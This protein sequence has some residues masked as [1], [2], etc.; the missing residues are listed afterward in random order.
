MQKN[1]SKKCK[2][3]LIIIFFLC[4]ELSAHSG[5][6]SGEKNLRVAKTKWFDIIYP[7]RC[8]ESAS[9]LFEKADTVYDEVT[10]QYG[11]TPSFRIPV[12]ITPAVEQFN[13]FW[14]GVP[15]NHIAIYDT[16]ASGD[17]DLS[18]FSETLLSTFRHELTHAVTYN[19]KNAFWRGMGKV[20]GDCVAPGMFSV[21]TGM[22][23][24]ATVA[25]ESSAGQGRL[26]DEFAKHY[27]KQ[28][29][30]EDKFPSYHDVSGASDV[31]PTSA[32]YYFNG[33]FHGWLQEKYGLPAYADFWWRVV[34]G[35]NFTIS[36]SFKKAFGIKLKKA[37]ALFE[38][39]YEVPEDAAA[40]AN[41]V[42]TGLVQDFF[43][44]DE[45]DY[46]IM[47]SAGFLYD[48]LSV[49]EKRL[50]WYD[51]ISSRVYT[52]S[53]ENPDSYDYVFTLRGISNISLS[54]D[55]RFLAVSYN[56]E[57]G[58]GVRARVRIYDFDHKTFYSVNDTGLRDAAVI[59]KNGDCYLVAQKYFAQHYSIVI[60]KLM[61]SDDGQQIN[62]TEP[63]AEVKLEAETNPYGFIPL[64]DGTFAYLKKEHLN[65]SIC[66]SDVDDSV[67]VLKE[68]A[69]PAGTVVRTFSYSSDEG[70]SD[71]AFYFSYAQKETMPRL[72]RLNLAANQFEFSEKDISGGVFNPVFWN[73][74]IVYIGEF[75]RQNR[76]LIM[77]E[78]EW[79]T[80]PAIAANNKNPAAAFPTSQL[81]SSIPSKTF[82]PFPYLL[83]GIIIPLSFYESNYFGSN[84]GYSSEYNRAYIG[85]TYLTATPWSSGTSELIM[86][87]GGWNTL[88]NSA[89]LS[90][91]VNS[92]TATSLFRSTTEVK[93]EFDSKG[94]KQ[95][96]GILTISTGFRTGNISRVSI[97]NTSYALFGRQDERLYIT[98]ENKNTFY[99]TYNFWDK[100]NIGILAPQID[101]IYMG[102]SDVISFSFSTIR[103]AGPGRFETQGIS[104]SVSYGVWYDKDFSN[105]EIEDELNNSI[106]AGIKVCIPRLL[107]FESKTGFTYNFPVTCNFKVLPS[108]KNLEK[109]AGRAVFAANVET[110]MFSIDIQKAI[111]FATAVFLNDF[112]I[113]GG[114]SGTGTAGSASKAG[115]Q[116]S[117][118]DD[119]FSAVSDG[120]GYYFDSIYLKTALEFIPNVGVLADSSYKMGLSVTYS[121]TL[122]S[123]KKLR[124]QE[125]T[126]ISL[127]LDM[128]F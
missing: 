2:N 56:S 93:S 103:K 60:F 94:W 116:T 125:R 40:A 96:G 72:G 76:L 67:S 37:W 39:E 3:F 8:E 49:S 36:G 82:S 46:S 34:N 68:F 85:A 87:T 109:S 17:G 65:Y 86:L 12:V 51:R 38:E 100:K 5:M 21:T 44:P 26:N 122:R 90:L 1:V 61:F 31:T 88:S 75:Y 33:A 111:P 16:G 57:N 104:A 101:D 107:P 27:V 84:I 18:V 41:P 126:K 97:S 11:L 95:G 105:S 112:Y 7:A 45:K 25:S 91:S 53:S 24:G 20:F 52:A 79:I 62:G 127:G 117:M 55:G 113:A 54:T 118:L 23:E 114:Y 110:T 89:G 22:A 29:K 6:L 77:N 13:A 119:Y 70:T 81:H 32:P 108:V 120:R 47:N 106:A 73:G 74:K 66:I 30:I 19:M 115:F 121:Y 58:V 28:A 92:G 124:P 35:K 83:R 59:Q 99:S 128:N 14:A 42:R 64:E 69:L 78:D 98:E 63:F 15:Y 10:E 4:A 102:L 9:V 123:L 50:A 43:E 71:G 80:S 48:S